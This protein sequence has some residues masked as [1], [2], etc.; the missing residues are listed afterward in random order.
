MEQNESLTG[1]FVMDNE[2]SRMK[3]GL[4]IRQQETNSDLTASLLS[5][6]S[7]SVG[8]LIVGLYAYENDENNNN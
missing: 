6:F 8:I 3:H 1:S 5:R 7:L 4:R 2:T